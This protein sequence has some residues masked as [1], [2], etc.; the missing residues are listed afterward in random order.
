M[1]FN[2]YL[3]ALSQLGLKYKDDWLQKL[4]SFYQNADYK[5]DFYQFYPKQAA[6]ISTIMNY[7]V[8]LQSLEKSN[9][10]LIN[11][12]DPSYPKQLFQIHD[13]PLLLFCLGNT[14]LLTSNLPALAII[15]SRK[16][17]DY[18]NQAINLIL[19][20]FPK[21]SSIIVSGLA[22]GIDTLAHKEAL[23]KQLPTI[24]V[25]GSGFD[26]E[27][28]Y[29]KNNFGLAQ[30]I[31]Q[32]GGLII[33]EYLPKELPRKHYFLA[34]NRIIAGLS[35][36]VVVVECKQKSGALITA[37]MAL[38]NNR[39]VFAIPGNITSPYSIGPNN[40][41]AEGAHI[42]YS[43]TQ[44]LTYFKI[45]P[46]A[47]NKSQNIDITEQE[48]NVLKFIHKSPTS[49]EQ[50]LYL[51]QP[52]TQDIKKLLATLSLLELKGLISKTNT[53]EFYKI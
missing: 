31:I 46:T 20:N 6:N 3:W 48:Q 21:F 33:S 44:L 23:S 51:L 37:Q 42:L 18:G 27:A 13:P 14:E 24:A 34:R 19:N 38:E 7:E 8:F 5:K 49:I 39:E 10:K 41:I 22:Y 9:P 11:I 16:H 17:G 32:S 12:F 50:I 4:K 45:K 40:L 52:E 36:A 30:K 25:L 15:G 53:D 1:N 28:L 29:P 2:Y 26:I 47:S 43:S 35:H